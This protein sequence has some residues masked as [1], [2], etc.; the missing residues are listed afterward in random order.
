[1]GAL[2]DLRTIF[3]IGAMTGGICAI[4]LFTSRRIHRPSESGLAWAAFAQLLLSLSMLMIALRG[5]I[6]DWVSVVLAN[7]AG[8]AGMIVLYESTRRLCQV[9]P[10][11]ASA[12]VA[13]V[14]PRP[15]DAALCRLHRP[16]SRARSLGSRSRHP[17][18]RF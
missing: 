13:A 4:T 17:P 10:R 8:P 15:A 3:L 5:L 11:P 14:F 7:S 2:F 6:P 18:R 9:P 12:G 16:L 1:M